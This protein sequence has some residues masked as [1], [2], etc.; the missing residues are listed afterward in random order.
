MVT[1]PVVHVGAQAA[2][3]LAQATQTPY[4]N[5]YPVR[6]VLTGALHTEVPGKQGIHTV[7]NNTY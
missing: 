6:Q 5:P 4:T 2:V 3:E 7:P 1:N